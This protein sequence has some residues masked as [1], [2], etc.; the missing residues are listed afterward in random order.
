MLES[1]AACPPCCRPGPPLPAI[2]SAEPALN[3]QVFLVSYKN[4]NYAL[5]QIGKA[6][7]GCA[8]RPRLAARA[9]VS[10]AALEGGGEE[11]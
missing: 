8:P 7:A 4:K 3:P 9:R 5:K 2:V 1:A 6:Q 11:P 10:A